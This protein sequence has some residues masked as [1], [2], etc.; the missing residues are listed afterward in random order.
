MKWKPGERQWIED[1]RELIEEKRWPELRNLL[2]PEGDSKG[3][4]VTLLTVMA[5][6][7]FLAMGTI[8]NPKR[9]I[10]NLT[11]DTCLFNSKKMPISLRIFNSAGLYSGN[12]PVEKDF[13]AV[14]RKYLTYFEIPENLIQRVLDNTEGGLT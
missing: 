7:K 9:K 12:K 2:P 14:I 6:G 13:E 1:H 4:I 8:T 10:F 5:N 11:L 3:R